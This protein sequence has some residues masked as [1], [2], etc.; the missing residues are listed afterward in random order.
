MPIKIQLNGKSM[1]PLIRMNR[2]IVTI[3]P[4]KREPVKGDIVMFLDIKGRYCAHRVRR[5]ETDRILT[6]GDN[7]RQCDPWTAKKDVAGLIISVERKGRKYSLDSPVLRFYG[8]VRMAL[9]PVRNFNHSLFMK[10][11]SVYVKLFKKDRG[12]NSNA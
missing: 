6:L 10:L 4:L 9:L 3:V 7:C 8:K 1:E 2:D 5:V 12:G 11:W